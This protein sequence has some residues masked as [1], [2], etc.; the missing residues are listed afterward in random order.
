MISLRLK[1]ALPHVIHE[2]QTGFMSER[3][4]STNIWK[5]IDLSMIMKHEKKEGILLSCDF[6]KCFDRVE[7]VCIRQSLKYF[8]FGDYLVNWVSLLYSDFYVQVQNN[9]N[10]SE[11]LKVT[12]SIHQGGCCSAELFLICAETLAHE[13][14]SRQINGIK[15]RNY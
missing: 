9:G 13:L 6:L 1:K 2:D 10:F 4:I 5:I 15:L 3:R 14:R 11:E 8:G 7:F 12:R